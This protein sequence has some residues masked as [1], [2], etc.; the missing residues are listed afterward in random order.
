MID[1]PEAAVPAIEPEVA[2]WA[3]EPET[4]EPR[5]ETPV[6]APEDPPTEETTS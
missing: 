3:I 4:A 6:F 2:L 1:E 5:P